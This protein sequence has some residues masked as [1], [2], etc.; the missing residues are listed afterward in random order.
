MI[1]ILNEQVSLKFEKEYNGVYLGPETPYRGPE[2]QVAT[3]W[4]K[5][6]VFRFRYYTHFQTG[7]PILVVEAQKWMDNK[8]VGIEWSLIVYLGSNPDAYK[9]IA[10][11]IANDLYDAEQELDEDKSLTSREVR[12]ILEQHGTVHWGT[13]EEHMVR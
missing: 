5:E 12:K 2:V 10:E 6:W 8:P 9:A 13:Y 11:V 7:K 1:R 4:M 3:L